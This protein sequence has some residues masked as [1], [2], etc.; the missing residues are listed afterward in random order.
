MHIGT[1]CIHATSNLIKHACTELLFPE[2]NIWPVPELHEK[3]RVNF[4]NQQNANQNCG[5]IIPSASRDAK[6]E[7]SAGENV[8][9]WKPLCAVDG[10]VK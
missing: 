7:V 2:K 9:K 8:E 6:A 1:P 5:E 3:N 4:T 10:S